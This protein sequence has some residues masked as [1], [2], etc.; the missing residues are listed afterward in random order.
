VQLKR[1]QF[2]DDHYMSPL[3]RQL[4]RECTL[5]RVTVIVEFL[6]KTRVFC[7]RKWIPDSSRPDFSRQGARGVLRYDA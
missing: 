3:E 6:M 7:C 2:S 1:E 4:E 5:E